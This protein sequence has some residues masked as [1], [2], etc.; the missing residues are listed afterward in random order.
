VQVEAFI[1]DRDSHGLYDYE[2]KSIVR[3][4]MKCVGCVMVSRKEQELKQ[5]IPNVDNLEEYQNLISIV[6]KNN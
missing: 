1:W 4:S 2:S 3:Q 5:V 6:P